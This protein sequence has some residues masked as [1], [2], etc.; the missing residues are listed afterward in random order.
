[1]PLLT[2]TYHRTFRNC[3]NKWKEKVKEIISTIK[4]QPSLITTPVKKAKAATEASFEGPHGL[5]QHKK[6]F[7]GGIIVRG[8]ACLAQHLFKDCKWSKIYNLVLILWRGECLRFGCCKTAITKCVI[9]KCDQHFVNVHTNIRIQ[10]V[11][12]DMN[13]FYQ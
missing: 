8:N 3:T 7:T 10:L 12:L 6:P 11:W 5:S 9:I 4:C 1:M 13:T 2:A